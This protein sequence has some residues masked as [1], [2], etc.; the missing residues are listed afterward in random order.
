M[1]ETVKNEI[2]NEILEAAGLSTEV[3]IVV[4]RLNKKE[5]I[6]EIATIKNGS[7]N[8]IL[9]KETKNGYMWVAALV[10]TLAKIKFVNTTILITGDY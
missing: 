9:T 10:L 6:V 2:L 7:K 3:Q 1:K 5:E 4:D 8:I